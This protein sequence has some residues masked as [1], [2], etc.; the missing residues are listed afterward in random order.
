V[1][2]G[3][4]PD[5]RQLAG[6]V[7]ALLETELAA[8]GY[9]LLDVRVFPG[10]GRLQVRVYVDLPDGGITLD[11]CARASRSIGMLLE[12]ADLIAG[13]YV[14][15]V[16]SPGVRRPLRTPAHFAA[17]VGQRIDLKTADGRLRC[18][19][20]A[21]DG[22]ML[23]VRPLADGAEPVALRHGAVREANLDPDFDAQALINEDRRRRK[24][25]KREARRARGKKERRRA[26]KKDRAADDTGTAD[27]G[28]S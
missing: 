7:I 27:D 14:L 16:S 22:E 10:G 23:T 19:L 17:A 18:E 1:S 11:Q 26:R 5:P 2:A 21:V 13:Q 15:E 20:L 25:E 6:G 12:E 3:R 28:R 24:E 4:N 9:E 8:E